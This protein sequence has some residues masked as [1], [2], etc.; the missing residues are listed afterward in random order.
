MHIFILHFA[1][2]RQ[3]VRGAYMDY[4]KDRSDSM[5]K[6]SPVWENYQE[7]SNSYDG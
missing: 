4:E 5:G 1:N 6:R 2:L 3:V 7:T